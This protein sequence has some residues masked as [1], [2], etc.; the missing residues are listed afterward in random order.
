MSIGSKTGLQQHHRVRFAAHLFSAH[1]YIPMFLFDV[2]D[3][4]N[5]SGLEAAFLP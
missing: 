4:G 2:K 3:I 5:L 1:C